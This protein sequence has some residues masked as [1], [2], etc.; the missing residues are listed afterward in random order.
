M[1][2]KS[3]VSPLLSSYISIF[4]KEVFSFQ[5]GVFQ[6]F[7]FLYCMSEHPKISCFLWGF[8]GGVNIRVAFRLLYFKAEI[9]TKIKIL[10][11]FT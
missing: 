9:H 3:A 6:K 11:S 7:S 5:K 10:S 4:Q 2:W 1:E 8:V